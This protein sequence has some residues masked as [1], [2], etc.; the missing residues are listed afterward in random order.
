MGDAHHRR[1]R[2]D[3]PGRRGVRVPVHRRQTARPRHHETWQRYR[4]TTPAPRARRDP[5]YRLR[6]ILRVRRGPPLT[7]RQWDWLIDCMGRGDPDSEI[8]VAWQC[9][10][11]VRSA[12]ASTA[13]ATGRKIAEKIVVTLASCPIGEIARLGQTCASGSPR[14]WG[15]SPPTTRAKAAPKRR[16]GSSSCTAALPAATASDEPTRGRARMR[17]YLTAE[18]CRPFTAVP[19]PLHAKE[20]A[21]RNGM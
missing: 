16:T 2:E 17:P 21:G 11:Q 4:R 9:Y 10:Q 6:N 8:H 1:R 13:L 15:T 7:D 19:Y 18:S 20:Q 3:P 12:Y 5:L 14:T